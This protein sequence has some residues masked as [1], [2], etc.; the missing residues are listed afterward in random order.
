MPSIALYHTNASRKN[1]HKEQ[2]HLLIRF[3]LNSLKSTTQPHH[4][5]SRIHHQTDHYFP[6]PAELTGGPLTDVYRLE[7]FHLHWGSADD[8]GSEHTIDGKTFAA[9]VSCGFCS[10][11]CVFNYTNDI[12]RKDKYMC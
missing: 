7:Q 10:F 9:E 8:H 11:V 12:F 2:K 5:P 3:V 1:P 6:F 4:F